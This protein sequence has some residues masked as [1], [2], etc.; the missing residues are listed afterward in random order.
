MAARAGITRR[1]D[2]CSRDIGTYVFKRHYAVCKGP[3]IEKPRVAWNKGLT[4][5]DPRVARNG[6]N[7][8]LVLQGRKKRPLTG[9]ERLVVSDGMKRAH[10]EGR[11]HNIGESRWKLEP[12]YPEKFFQR[13][14]DNEFEDKQVSRELFVKPFAVDFA[15]EHKKLAIEIDGEQHEQPAQVT[16][17]R[18]KD[19]LLISLGWKVLRITWKDMSNDTRKWIAEAKRF[20]D[21]NDNNR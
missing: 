20:V 19:A 14:I 8:G 15:W 5:A 21:D 3:K 16:R 1:C 2:K 17:D 4:V 6:I 11:A 18:R 13:V 12:S 9:E 7:A 10:A